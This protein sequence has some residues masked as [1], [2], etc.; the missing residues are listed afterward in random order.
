MPHEADGGGNTPDGRLNIDS[1]TFNPD[2]FERV[3]T[4]ASDAYAKAR[5][6]ERMDPPAAA[7]TPVLSAG[8][9]WE[10]PRSGRGCR[11]P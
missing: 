8:F 11:I 2:L 7:A 1:G 3:G 4:K 5:L 10:K 9:A 6:P